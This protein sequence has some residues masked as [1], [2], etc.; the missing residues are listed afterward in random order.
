MRCYCPA[1]SYRKRSCRARNTGCRSGNAA[2]EPAVSGGNRE[3]AGVECHGGEAAMR[4]KTGLGALLLS[5]GVTLAPT[6]AFAQSG[7][8]GVDLPADP[9]I[10]IPLYHPRADVVGGVYTAL[11]FVMYRQT[12]P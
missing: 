7:I 9:I 5:A 11:E 4:S 6:L 3:R 1:P 2:A 12:N 10:P 8:K